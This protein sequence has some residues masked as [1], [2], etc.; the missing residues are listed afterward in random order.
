MAFDLVDRVVG[1]ILVYFRNDPPFY[2]GMESMSQ[3]CKRARRRHDNESFHLP[4]TY[5][6]FHRD[7]HPL[8]EA[9][10]LEIVPIGIFNP[11]AQ[12]RSSALERAARSVSTL[13][14]SRR[15]FVNENTLGLEVWES[16][17][18]SVAQEKRLAAITDE[19]ESIVGNVEFAHARFGHC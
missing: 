14:M 8:D 19:Y 13:L 18:T 15:V 17:V 12:I 4:L 9:M 1:E 2:V 3:I 16:L 6:T 5:E 10:L 7:G 11:A